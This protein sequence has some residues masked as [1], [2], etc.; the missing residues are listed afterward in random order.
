MPAPGD[1]TRFCR[2]ILENGSLEAKLRE[3]DE[4]LLTSSGPGRRGQPA[5]F[6]DA[7][8]RHGDLQFVTT[9][10]RLPRFHELREPAARAACLARFAHHELMAVE[11]FAW[12]LLAY[13][14]APDALRRGI[15]HALRDEQRHC[16]LYLERL[17]EHGSGLGDHR[18]TNYFW[19]NIPT[20]RADAQ[21]LEAFLAGMGLTLEQANLDFSRAYGEAFA[22]AGDEATARVIERVH[23][24]EIGHVRLAADWLLVLSGRSTLVEAYRSAI[25]FPL[26]AARAKGRQFHAEA[27]RRAGLPE[28]FIEYV[29][30]AR[31]TQNR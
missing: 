24:D 1:V 25:R 11:L 8:A 12:S 3:P 20:R 27:R 4:A 14:E 21:G 22:R 5:V 13:P 7:P 17:A 28:D 9:A 2:T 6:V 16:R 26:Q 15:L 30:T 10:P 18:H 19:K 29:R 31:S 23:R